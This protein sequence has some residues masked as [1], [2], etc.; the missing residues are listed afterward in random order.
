MN[1]FFQSLRWLNVLALVCLV[2]GCSSEP[3]PVEVS[4]PT[5]ESQTAEPE[6]EPVVA[7][8]GPELVADDGQTLWV[9]PT[10]GEPLPLS[11]VPNGTQLLLHVRPAE[12]LQHAEDEKILAA[13]GPAGAE[14]IQSL[15]D[16][17]GV[18]M[19]R[20]ESLTAA[21][22]PTM[23]GDMLTT[24]RLELPEPLAADVV[25]PTSGERVCYLPQVAGRRIVICGNFHAVDDLKLQGDEPALFSR[26]MQK[27]L[28]RT[29][30]LRSATLVL[31]TRFLQI[32]GHKLLG[33][34]AKHLKEL[35]DTLARDEATSLALSAHW[36]EEFFL[37]LQSTVKLNVQAHRFAKD[38]STWLPTAS[39]TLSES[40]TEQ[41]AHPFGRPVVDRLPAMIRLLSEYT[42]SDEDDG[43]SV[44]RCYLPVAAGHNLLMAGE[45]MLGL[46]AESQDVAAGDVAAQTIAEKLAQETSMSFPKDTLEQALALLSADIEVPIEIA[47]R[48]LQLE[49]ITKNQIVWHRPARPVGGIDFA[50]DTRPGESR[51]HRDEPGRPQAETGVCVAKRQHC[52]GS[53]RSDDTSG[54]REAGRDAARG[55][56]PRIEIIGYNRCSGTIVRRPSCRRSQRPKLIH[57]FLVELFKLN[58]V[59]C[60]AALS[61][62]NESLVG[63][64]IACPRCG[65]MVEVTRP[66]EGPSTEVDP[67]D[68]P[69]TEVDSPD[70]PSTEVDSPD[71]GPTA[72][73][74][75]V[76]GG[77]NVVAWSSAVLVLGLGALAAVAF[78]PS[79]DV[80]VA[81]FVAQASVPGP[82]DREQ[83]V[84]PTEPV[85]EQPVIEQ[86][87]EKVPEPIV[88]QVPTETIDSAIDKALVQEQVEVTPSEGGSGYRRVCA[89]NASWFAIA[90]K[91][92]RCA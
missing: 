28:D 23:L 44:H 75:S 22:H 49:G 69:S 70:N 61:V 21:V 53:D 24:W 92:L 1:S 88:E 72:V 73:G 87:V 5:V 35:L 29:D 51:S 34:S 76:A 63:Q 40:L 12:L 54:C 16:A 15:T 83:D 26:D 37:E 27:L 64:I 4:E 41:P 7:P 3:A 43:V 9:S 66:T 10:A 62:R 39:R 89:D 45:L 30:R 59:T 47:G 74:S 6:V 60:Q 86:V 58:C 11:Y 65:S 77:I 48:D 91:N 38:V 17:T 68:N 18:G 2:L 78:W 25:L 90:N 80:P 50:G 20:I 52:R 82:V 14:V 56:C 55:V 36:G 81:T 71:A 46:P 31:P 85:V 57:G 33:E 84:E 32:G 79:E 13:L 42:R 19:E 8:T 67:P